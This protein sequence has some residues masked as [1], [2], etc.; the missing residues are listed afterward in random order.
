KVA[1]PGELTAPE[2]WVGQ[3]RGTVRFHDAVNTLRDEGVGLCLEVGPDAVLTGMIRNGQ[4]EEETL[5]ALP[6][7]RAGHSETDVLGAGLAQAHAHGA[8]IDLTAFFPGAAPADLPTYAFR[9]RRYWLTSGRRANGRPT[10][11]GTSRHPLLDTVVELADRGETVLSGWFS[12]E[13]H[14]WLADHTIDGNVIL[15]AAVFL[16]LG[17]AAAART[18]ASGVEQFTLEA[19]LPL[20]EGE[21]VRLQIIVRAADP[22][23]TRAFSVH[24]RPADRDTGEAEWTRCASGS[25]TSATSGPVPDTFASLRNWPPQHSTEIPLEGIYDRLDRLGYAYGPTFRGLRGLWQRGEDLYAEVQLP[26]ELHGEAEQFA[27][28]P[29]LL[30]AALQPL[31]VTSAE[32]LEAGDLLWLPFDWHGA[33]FW[34]PDGLTSLRVRL[35]LTGGDDVSV[36]IADHHGSPVAE[37]R[38]LTLRQMSRKRFSAQFAAESPVLHAVRWE[39]VA[40]SGV[41]GELVL[42]GGGVPGV[43]GTHVFEVPVG[44]GGAGA[45][46]PGGVRDVVGGVLEWVRGWLAD[47]RFEGCRL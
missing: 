20:P 35:T 29:V 28:H 3:L 37:T 2:Y 33:S 26:Q 23:G 43:V 13:D 39:R 11:R 46:V 25:L 32:T 41:V 30:D 17:A 7:L 38:T 14:P 16:E 31:A 47:E 1:V 22:D 42:V 15:P 6:L 18:G 40:V 45:G 21:A 34:G 5:T 24:A 10:A 44:A 12:A 4:G 19:P 27:I 9:H 36:A 8:H